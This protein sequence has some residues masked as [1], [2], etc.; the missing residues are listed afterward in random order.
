M[1]T[2]GVDNNFV[3]NLE[4]G[5]YIRYLSSIHTNFLV[6]NPKRFFISF[7]RPNIGIWAE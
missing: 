1:E 4:E 6:V 7:Y 2:C 3:E 5:R